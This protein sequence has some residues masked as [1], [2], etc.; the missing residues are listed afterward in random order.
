M[1]KG[2][3]YPVAN[4]CLRMPSRQLVG[5]S[6]IQTF[7]S[8]YYKHSWKLQKG[9]FCSESRKLCYSRAAHIYIFYTYLCL[10]I[11]HSKYVIF[12]MILPH[13]LGFSYC[14]HFILNW[15]PDLGQQPS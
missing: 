11:F 5:N 6:V 4:D 14:C 2:L 7:S 13:L 15:F 10:Q 8:H 3:D 1:F 9:N 12:S